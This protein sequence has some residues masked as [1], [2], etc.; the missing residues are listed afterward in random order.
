MFATSRQPARGRTTDNRRRAAV[1][2]TRRPDA[3]RRPGS[4][5]RLPD[6]G[7]RHAHGMRPPIGM[8]LTDAELVDRVTAAAAGG[9]TPAEVEQRVGEPAWINTT[10][11]NDR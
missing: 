9:V 1:S 11:P 5:G 2:S 8:P 6:A 7:R 10:R 4:E 3:A